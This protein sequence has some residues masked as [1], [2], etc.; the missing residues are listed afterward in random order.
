MLSACGE[1]DT[2]LGD[3]SVGISG[4]TTPFAAELPRSMSDGG[5]SFD[6]APS[7]VL[8]ADKPAD[9]LPWAGVSP[10]AEPESFAC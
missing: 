3:I 9:K 7:V 1:F 10:F 4:L 2:D 6:R 5:A 8:R